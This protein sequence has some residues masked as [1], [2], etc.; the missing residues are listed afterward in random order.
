MRKIIKVLCLILFLSLFQGTIYSQDDLTSDDFKKVGQAGFKFLSIGVGTRNT[1]MG[2]AAGTNE[3]DPVSVFW[4]PAGIAKMKNN[5]VFMGYTQW[6]ADI[7]QGS[8][9]A[10]F[11]VQNIGSFALSFSYFNYGDIEK[12]GIPGS[13][14]S[15]FEEGIAYVDLGMINPSA[16]TVGLTYSR[17]LTDRFQVGGTVKY[18]YENLIEMTMGT[19]AIDFG[20]IYS[21]GTH[22][23]KISAIMQ[24]FA[25]SELSYIQQDFMLPLTFKIGFSGDILSVAGYELEESKLILAIETVK[26]RDYSERVHLGMEYIYNN[27]FVLRGGYKFNYD[28]E[29]FTLGFSI[30][31]S[32][33]DL[34][35]S[36]AN[37]DT[38]LGGGVN[39]FDLQYYF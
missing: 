13:G 17:A 12:T 15:S 34:G 37:F 18:A 6:F 30:K 38:K 27:M 32:G 16:L 35:Y 28:T 25:F 26:P 23:L 3:M 4:N 24:N 2:G 20:T 11:P 39:R 5:A 22:E 1:A 8:L 14:A 9:S 7:D 19:I 36:F 31:N 29:N 21:V 33:F 10:V